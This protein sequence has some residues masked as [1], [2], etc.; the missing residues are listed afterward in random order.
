M[1]FDHDKALKASSSEPTNINKAINIA[2]ALQI[3]DTLILSKVVPLEIYKYHN[4][5]HKM[6]EKHTFYHR[7]IQ[8]SYNLKVL[9]NL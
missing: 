7:K 5:V 8:Y 6:L 9:P 3:Y 1:G 4:L 2:V